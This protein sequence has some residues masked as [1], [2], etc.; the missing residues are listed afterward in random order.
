M[1][2]T[3]S[4]SAGLKGLKRKTATAMA[5]MRQPSSA[6]E[7]AALDLDGRM[8]RTATIAAAIIR[9]KTAAT[10]EISAG[11]CVIDWLRKSEIIVPRRHSRNALTT[12]S[13]ASNA[14]LGIMPLRSAR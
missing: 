13:A 2:P 9:K 14:G 10:R 11:A 12:S 8:N 7:T 1:N 6:S 3:G 4:G 5:P